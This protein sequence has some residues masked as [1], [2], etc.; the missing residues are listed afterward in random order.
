ME[1]REIPARLLAEYRS[2][3]TQDRIRPEDVDPS[4]LDYHRPLLERLDAVEGSSVALYDLAAQRYAFLT[5]S[6]RFL[7]GYDRED[8]LE[9]GPDYFYGRMHPEDLPLVLDTVTRALRFLRERPAAERTDY[10][11]RFD[12]RMERAGGGTVRLLQQVLV[13]EQDRRGRIWLVLIVNDLVRDGSLE[14]RTAREMRR[15]SDGTLHL[16]PAE[17]AEAETRPRLSRREIEILGLVAAGMA[18]REIADR[19]F[20]SVATVNNHRQH[21]LEKTGARNSAEAVRYAASL[22]LLSG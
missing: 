16:F 9:R 18:S 20:L 1:G 4:R 12:F 13:L 15:M 5:S 8:A 19:L 6:F 21:I 2:V 11:L 7:L 22:G 14:A 17:G 3:L 10:R